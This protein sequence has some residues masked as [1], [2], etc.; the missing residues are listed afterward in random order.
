MLISE[1]EE[2][3]D[4]FSKRLPANRPARH[5]PVWQVDGQISATACI[6]LGRK[7]YRNRWRTSIWRLL[8]R[9]WKTFTK[10]PS[11]WEHHSFTTDW[12]SVLTY[13]YDFWD[14]NIKSTGSS[15]RSWGS[16]SPSLSIIF[17][18]HD[19]LALVQR[20][21]PFPQERLFQRHLPWH[22]QIAVRF[23]PMSGLWSLRTETKCTS[24]R[25]Q[26]LRCILNKI[27]KPGVVIR[28]D[29]LF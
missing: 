2:K 26:V 5:A 17:S 28:R 25:W 1:S 27:S 14:S 20:Q 3:I 11:Y 8:S 21:Q 12:A 24:I 15:D 19:R 23:L 10:K 16:H 7:T 6:G 29:S 18:L 13:K 22:R 9:R 4:H